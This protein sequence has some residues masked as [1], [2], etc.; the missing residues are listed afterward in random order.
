MTLFR[1]ILRV[2]PEK[3]KEVL[4]TLLSLT[5]NPEMEIGCLSYHIACDIKDR[6]MFNMLSEWKTRQ[7][8]DNYLR[9][10]K[11]SI[12]LGTK[13]LLSEPIGF[14]IYSAADVEGIEAVILVR[15]NNLVFVA[16]N[17]GGE[18]GP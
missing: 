9:S 8:L 2:L 7:D 11:F 12:L 16:H 1:I 5:E 4:Q 13:S 14:Q 3:Q 18:P 6:N 10:D 17:S 15:K